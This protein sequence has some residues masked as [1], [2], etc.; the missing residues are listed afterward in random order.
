MR[1]FNPRNQRMTIYDVMEQQGRLASNPAN[2]DS[3]SE[4]GT[5]LYKGPVQYP[6]M[7]YHPQGELRIVVPAEIIMTP[8]GPK[9]VGLQTEIIHQ[10]VADE[11]EEAALR[12][13]GWH[14]HPA[15]A[16]AASGGEA[17]AMS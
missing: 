17:P 14:D 16:I 4:D 8:L 11:A 5:Q 9:A 6:R 12:A 1:S 3:M 7:M 10:V 13:E 2:V 15:K